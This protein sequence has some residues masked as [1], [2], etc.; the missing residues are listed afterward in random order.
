MEG[1]KKWECVLRVEG[2]EGKGR[3]GTKRKGKEEIKIEKEWR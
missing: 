2:R 3:I 1:S